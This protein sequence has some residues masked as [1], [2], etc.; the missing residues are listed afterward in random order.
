VLQNDFEH[1]GEQH[2]FKIKRQCAMMIQEPLRPDSIIANF[3]RELLLVEFCNN[4]CQ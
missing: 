2:R 4:I 3:F 1:F